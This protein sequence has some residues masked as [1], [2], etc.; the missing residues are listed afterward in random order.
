MTESDPGPDPLAGR[1]PHPREQIDLWPLHD[2]RQEL[3]EEIVSQPGPGST[4]RP[5]TRR[6]LVPVGIVAALALVAG[7]AWFAISAGDDDHTADE[8]V[9]APSVESTAVESTTTTDPT[10]ATDA[11]EPAE[12]ASI[13]PPDEPRRD[14]RTINVRTLERCMELLAGVDADQRDLRRLPKVLKRSRDGRYIV[15]VVEKDKQVFAIDSRCHRVHVKGGR[16]R[17][18]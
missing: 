18:H 3:L 8:T 6:V 7:G 11:P 9:A 14:R 15:Y 12:S 2:A 5:P 4:A 10:T 16:L 1:D 13:A 17:R